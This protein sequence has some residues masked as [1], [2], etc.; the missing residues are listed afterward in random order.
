MSKTSHI[1]KLT[2]QQYLNH[3][4]RLKGQITALEMEIILLKSDYI[5]KNKQL[6][7]GQKV[8]AKCT[9][10]SADGRKETIET[11]VCTGNARVDKDGHIWYE[12]EFEDGYLTELRIDFLEVVS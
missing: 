1:E 4:N 6:E 2:K 11:A 12:M 3:L 9:E 8:K 10:I 5:E 7:K